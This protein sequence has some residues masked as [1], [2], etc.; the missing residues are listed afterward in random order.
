MASHPTQAQPHSELNSFRIRTYEICARKSFTIRTYVEMR[1]VA[2]TFMLTTLARPFRGG[3][4]TERPY[5]ERAARARDL[6]ERLP[7]Y[8]SSKCPIFFFLVFR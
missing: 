4:A 1:G 3:D 5:P 8:T 2:A 6:G 7:G